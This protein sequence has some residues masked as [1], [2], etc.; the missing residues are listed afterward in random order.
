MSCTDLSGGIRFIINVLVHIRMMEKNRYVKTTLYDLASLSKTAGTLLA[1]MKLYD[2][3]KFGLTDK[4]SKYLP[5]LK[6]TNKQNITIQDLL[7]HESG[8]PAYYPFYRRLIDLK[9]CK[10]GLFRKKPDA[11]HKLQIAPNLYA[12]TDF[13]FKKEW[14]SIEPSPNYP[15]QVAASLYCKKRIS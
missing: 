1:I 3:G 9:T 12:C 4:A 6:S 11:H 8:L 14:V 10:G 2:E 5:F 15:L 13:S 7:Y